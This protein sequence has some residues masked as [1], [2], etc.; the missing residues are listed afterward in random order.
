MSFRWV[1]KSVTLNNHERRNASYFA[2][3]Q[4]IRVASDEFLFYSTP[5]YSHCKRC[6]SYGS[7]V[8]LSVRLSH[9]VLCQNDG[10]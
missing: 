9:A 10:T 6:T 5:Q 1:P 3:F 4:R 7:S 2:L 8:C